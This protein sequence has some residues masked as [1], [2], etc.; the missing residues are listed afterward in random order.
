M[1][2]V[3]ASNE[4]VVSNR[5]SILKVVI[6]ALGLM[7]FQF[8]YNKLMEVLLIDVV[9]KAVTGLTN[10]CYLMIHHTMQFLILFIPTMIIYRTK[11]LDFGYW[12]KNYKASR[13][14][15]IL[16]ATYALLISLI[17]AIM[18]AYRKFELDDFIFQ[19]FFSGLGEEIL[20]RSLP[21]TVLILAGGKDYEFDIKGK[22]TLSISVAI[23]A[24][25]FA[26]GHVSIARE[27]ISFSTM[28]LLCCLIVGM[29]LGDC[30]KR[31]H[32]IWI[33]MFIHGFIN[34][35]SL[36]FNMAFVFLLSALA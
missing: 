21:I 20:F 1:M 31:T 35:L 17:T 26:L 27:G 18:G 4:R 23:S 9:A 5:R 8:F 34:V 6:A 15:I 25:L 33:C 22:Y 30:Y 3:K 24:V 36:V 16:G 12:N 19:L 7:V 29:I 28:Q 10:S 2:E 32:N 13:R 14:Y 11:K